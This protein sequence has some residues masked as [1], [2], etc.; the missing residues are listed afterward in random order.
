MKY[1]PLPA[2]LYIKNRAKLAA[3]MAKNSVAIFNSNDIMPTNADGT[4]KFR[5]NNDLFYLSG[6]DQEE[7]ILL[8]APD[9][10]NPAMREVLFLRE[11]N[12][13]IAIWEGHKY[14]KEEAEATS[15]I[16]NIQWLDKFDLIFSTVMALS[17]RVYLN[18]NEHLRAGVVVETRD[19]RFIKTCKEQF[20]LHEYER[21]APLMHE[22]R[23]VKEQEEIDQ[24]Q[25]ACDI[26]EK[27]FRRI[28]NFVKPGVT[29]YEIEAEYLHEFV[30]NR[31]KGFAYEPIIA[32]GISACVLH[33]LENNKACNDGE[34]LLMDVGAEYGNYNADMTRTIPVSGKFTE[35]QKAVYNAVLRVH[36]EASSMLRPGVTIQDYHKEVGLIMQS[37]LIGLGLV[38]QTDV[39]NQD[40]NWPAYKKYFMH[41]T[42]HHLGLDVH[43]VGTMYGP[44]QPG[45]VFTV[46]P[47]IYIPE[48]GFGIRLENDIVVLENG[49]FDLMKNIPIEA[50]EIEDL[51]NS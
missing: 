2:S 38:D 21:A 24:L 51:M 29:E 23:G 7:S 3:K 5:Q 49:Y 20:P 15:G 14:T 33:Y 1:T 22:L 12:E 50:D 10:P 13:H 35:R 39:Q 41:G 8:L 36:K 43:D 42:S 40:P 25:I 32:S 45:M 48:E 30:R 18:T 28:L 4:M 31:S 16:K 34:L 11:T 44:I 37:E 19:A 9:C 6:I 47:G 46:E 27:G 26:T 17:D